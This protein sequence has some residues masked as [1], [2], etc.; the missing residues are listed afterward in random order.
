[1]RASRNANQMI[2][3]QETFRDR[4]ADAVARFGG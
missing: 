3:E 4:I 2:E 1:M